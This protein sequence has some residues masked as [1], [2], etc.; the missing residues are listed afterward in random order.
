VQKVYTLVRAVPERKHLE[1]TFPRMEGYVFD[2][3]SRIQVD[4]ES[5][6]Y[7]VISSSEGF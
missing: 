6:L 1:I 2:V 4:W 3:H 7:L 5:V